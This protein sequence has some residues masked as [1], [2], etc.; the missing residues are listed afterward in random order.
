MVEQK[1]SGSNR[2]RKPR[3]RYFFLNG[4]LHKKL[5]IDR[6]KDVITAWSYPEEKRV[7]YTYS[8]VIRRHEKA[9]TTKEVAAMIGRGRITI[10]KAVV[11]GNVERPQH[12]YGLESKKI[13]QYMWSEQDIMNLHDYLSTVHRGRPRKDGL[14]SPQAMPTKR[15][16]RAMVRQNQILYVKDADGEFRPTWQAEQF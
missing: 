11:L 10:E 2:R 14:V 7:G 1:G 3:I 5:H 4:K 13:F 15:E 8:D 6:G 12:T 16:L 9:W